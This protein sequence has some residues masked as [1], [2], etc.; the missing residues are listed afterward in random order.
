LSSGKKTTGPPGRGRNRGDAREKPEA[1]QQ[2]GKAF[3]L[4]NKV[5]ER[6]SAGG[7]AYH[8][9]VEL[10]DRGPTSVHFRKEKGKKKKCTVPLGGEKPGRA[11]PSRG[12]KAAGPV[13]GNCSVD[14][15]VGDE[16]DGIDGLGKKKRPLAVTNPSPGRFYENLRNCPKKRGTR[17]RVGIKKKGQQ[18]SGRTWRN[19]GTFLSLTRKTKTQKVAVLYPPEKERGGEATRGGKKARR[20]P[21]K[22]QGK[23]TPGY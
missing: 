2:R 20:G 17:H 16:R 9:E 14:H 12:K 5:A 11:L 6:G 10:H 23:K 4:G 15:L 7:P 1:V 18:S 3:L 8:W 21:L 13:N 22:P 19:G